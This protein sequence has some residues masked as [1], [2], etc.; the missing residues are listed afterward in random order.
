MPCYDDR[1]VSTDKND[2]DVKTRLA[3]EYLTGLESKGFQI[4]EYAKDWWIRHKEFDR[5]RNKNK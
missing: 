3:C 1:I 2:L 5:F 4:P